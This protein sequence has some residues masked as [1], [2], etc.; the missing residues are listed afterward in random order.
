[1]AALRIISHEAPDYR[2]QVD[3]LVEL[4]RSGGLVAGDEPQAL[5]VAKIVADILAQVRAGGDRA[6]AELTSRLD[7]AAIS[8]AAL[9]VP[10]AEIARAHAQADPDF[11]ALIRRAI[12]NIRAYQEQIRHRDP[13]PL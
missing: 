3:A 6:A 7:R 5:D 11:L 8:A 13:E 9:R 2:A 1:M 12:A 4:L 10:E